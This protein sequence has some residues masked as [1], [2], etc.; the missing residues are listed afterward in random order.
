MVLPVAV[1]LRQPHIRRVSLR[2]DLSV[3][4]A[5]D[6]GKFCMGLRTIGYL[7][8]LLISGCAPV[9]QQPAPFDESPR[10][11]SREFVT[12]DGVRLPLSTW[13]PE[14][15][16][17]GAVIAV[18]G[19]NDYRAAFSLPGPYWAARGLAVYAYD[20]RGFGETP[21]RGVWP[22]APLL[23]SDLQDLFELVRARHPGVPTFLLGDSMGAAVVLLA[24][25]DP[26]TPPGL[27]GIILNAPAAWGRET[28]NPL[29][30]FVLWTAAHTVPWWEVTGSGLKIRVT[31]NIEHLRA[32]SRDPLMIRE[33]RID[34][35]YGI[36]QLMGQA[37]DRA[38]Q[39][40]VPALVLYGMK[41]EVIPRHAVC[42]LVE[43]LPQQR[44]S[45]WY[46][47]GYH[48]LLR[49]LQAVDVWSD[50][51]AWADASQQHQ[52]P[53][54]FGELGPTSVCANA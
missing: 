50:V 2:G 35:L 12:R 24:A 30:R 47:N 9:V 16:P 42:R 54:F 6:G 14:A 23:V 43:L 15:A 3:G 52:A 31:D 10:L 7:V 41:D 4:C 22:G 49:D 28:F 1:R 32:V 37:L 11:Q 21:Q 29:Y 20:Q 33:T 17:R 8:L 48:W 53:H 13:L 18:H 5:A 36:V 39:L 26:H 25:A 40:H 38:A 27:A 46:A 45:L 44:D 34:A 51:A 19:F